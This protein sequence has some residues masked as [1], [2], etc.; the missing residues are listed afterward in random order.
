ML[1]DDPWPEGI[2]GRVYRNLLVRQW[3]GRDDEVLARREELASDVA[4]ARAQGDTE[5]ASVYMG[6]GV[7]QVNAIRP[8]GDVMREICAAAEQVLADGLPRLV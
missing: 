2:A 5:Q 6:Q 4:A 1:S 7:G 8:A 3:H